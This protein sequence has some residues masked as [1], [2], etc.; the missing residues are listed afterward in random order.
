MRVP[1]CSLTHAMAPKYRAAAAAAASSSS[2]H[3]SPGAKRKTPALAS[4]ARATAAASASIRADA[5]KRQKCSVRVR[6]II[7]TMYNGKFSSVEV[8]ADGLICDQFP[9]KIVRVGRCIIKKDETF[10][11]YWRDRVFRLADR[12]AGAMQIFV[13]TLTGKTI[14]LD[15]EYSDTIE[16]VKQKIQDKE[17]ISPD[18]QRMLFAGQQLEDGRTLDDYN[19]EMESTLHLILRLRGGGGDLPPV[20]MAKLSEDNM[21]TGECVTDGDIWRCRGDGLMIEGKC[22]AKSK[23]ECPA[24]GHNVIYV[25]GYG[26]FDYRASTA[27]CPCCGGKI[28]EFTSC[29]ASVCRWRYITETQDCKVTHSSLRTTSADPNK[30]ETPKNSATER[31]D[32]RHIVLQA[33]RLKDEYVGECAICFSHIRPDRV[34]GCGCAFHLECLYAWHNDTA[35]SLGATCAVCEAATEPITEGMLK[36]KI[37]DTA[38]EK[39]DAAKNDVMFALKGVEDAK[40]GLKDAEQRVDCATQRSKDLTAAYEALLVQAAKEEAVATAAAV[41]ASAAAPA[42]ASISIPQTVG[43]AAKI[44]TKSS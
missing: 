41:A 2:A 5:P 44:K 9:G 33:L 1:L 17:G 29:Y 35:A 32:Y 30:Y 13:K 28:T 36:C 34:L 6:R 23:Q 3:L 43:A 16:T 21:T 14:T 20:N 4:T 42:A 26:S 39:A 40:Q 38:R 31:Q 10:A 18:Q 19:I 27:C 12:A 25:F 24:Y 11:K 7:H 8:D 15:V 37:Q 22:P